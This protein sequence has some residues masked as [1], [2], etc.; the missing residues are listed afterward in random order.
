MGCLHNLAPLLVSVANRQVSIEEGDGKAR[1]CSV[2][3]I[4]TS[5]KAGLNIKVRFTHLVADQMDEVQAQTSQSITN[6]PAHVT[7]VTILMDAFM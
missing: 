5:A 6:C 2:H 1:E 4:E 3:F 7:H